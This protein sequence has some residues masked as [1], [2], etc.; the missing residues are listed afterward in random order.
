MLAVLVAMVPSD[1]QAASALSGYL[2][3]EGFINSGW[4]D[5]M[6]YDLDNSEE[7]RLRNPMA[8]VGSLR[9]PVYLYAEQSQPLVVVINQQFANRAQQLGKQCEFS[10]VPGDHMTMVQ[11]AV[12]RTISKFQNQVPVAAH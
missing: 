11:P 12:K 3:Y 6:P 5:A 4:R 7:R 1:Y 8:F 2:D 9:L 10:T